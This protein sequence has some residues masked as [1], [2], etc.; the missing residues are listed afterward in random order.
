MAVILALLFKG[1]VAEAF[2]IPTGSMAPTLQG[3][4]KDVECP[5]CNYRYQTTASDEVDRAG[6]LSGNHVISGT[7]PV[8]RFTH[9]FDP[10]A[11]ANEGSFSGDR[12]IVSK[13]AFEVA[14]PKRWD[15]IVFKFPEDASQNYIKRLVGLPGETL[16]IAGGNIFTRSAEE[17]PEAEGIARK[18]PH[19]LT[20]MLQI[21]D[22]SDHIPQALQKI[23]WPSRWKELSESDSSPG[24][25]K[26][27]DG[28][29]SFTCSP[30]TQT[31]WLR[32]RHLVPHYSDWQSI[33]V[34]NRLPD[35]VPQ[36][37]GQLITDLYAYNTSVYID[38]E[39]GNWAP[40]PRYYRPTVNAH[41]DLEEV[42]DR[43]KSPD[44][45]ELLYNPSLVGPGIPCS[46]EFLGNHWVDDLAVECLA[47]ISDSQGTI[48]LDLVRAGVH[49]RCT[50]NVQDG[51]AT[52][53]RIN[54]AGMA[55]PF[56]DEKNQEVAN[57]TATTAVKGAGV[58]RL[59]LT[60]CDH[61]VMLFVNNRPVK[62]DQA[63]TYHSDKV[64]APQWTPED[65]LDLAP[66]GVGTSGLKAKISQLRIFRDKYYIAIDG[67]YQGADY[68]ALPPSPAGEQRSLQQIFATPEVWPSSGLFDPMNR[69]RVEFSLGEDQFFP[70]GDNSPSSSDG[71]YWDP[72]DY[73][74]RDLLIGKALVIY[75]PHSWNRPMF[76]PNF[77]RMGRI[78]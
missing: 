15:V 20:A 77:Q 76:W 59:R 54:A 47:D 28:G 4:H 10:L 71:R 22:D 33:T 30:A 50:I 49:Q 18:P 52:L 45:R 74:T 78:R 23:G 16:R 58:Y 70:M 75:W 56:V 31:A 9:T 40:E 60:N 35:D 13:F 46:E 26:S 42:P 29:K 37:R 3:R 27:E 41:V 17:A 21:V 43:L 62:F 1:Y 36:R 19:K 61:E 44:G 64:V 8:C 51:K 14:E 38:T 32:Y 11:D 73:L 24:V 53:S 34:D 69:R 25:W 2:V 66:A 5:Q 72:N 48:S 12:I 57:P 55:L 63:T 7:C 65:P 39:S 67:G 6:Y 68:L